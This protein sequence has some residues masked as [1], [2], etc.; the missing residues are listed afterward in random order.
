[1]DFVEWNIRVVRTWYGDANNEASM[2]ESDDECYGLFDYFEASRWCCMQSQQLLDDPDRYKAT[3]Q[4][5]RKV[6]GFRKTLPP[7]I[8]EA[9]SDVICFQ[10]Y[11]HLWNEWSVLNTNEGALNPKSNIKKQPRTLLIVIDEEA[12]KTGELL[13]LYLNGFGQIIPSLTRNVDPEEFHQD[14]MPPENMLSMA[15]VRDMEEE[16]MEDLAEMEDEFMEDFM[17][18]DSDASDGW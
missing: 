18:L 12:T 3:A 9:L 8:V 14:F 17:E 10:D 2:E 7:F 15:E 16:I 1:M 4:E 13:L 11:N 6:K 5:T